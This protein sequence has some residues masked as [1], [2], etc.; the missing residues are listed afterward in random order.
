MSAK[1]IFILL[2]LTNVILVVLCYL[3]WN[4]YGF[5]TDLLALG[6]VVTSVLTLCTAFIVLSHFIWNLLKVLAVLWTIV[7]PAKKVDHGKE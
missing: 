3:T 2:C 6:I 5:V 7:K 1:L 4:F